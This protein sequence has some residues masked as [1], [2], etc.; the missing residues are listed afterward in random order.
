[1]PNL[2]F[3]V[4]AI[5]SGDDVSAGSSNSDDDVPNEHDR[6]F[7]QDS[8]PTQA[9]SSY[10]QTQVYRQSLLTQAPQVEGLMFATRPVRRGRFGNAAAR[11]RPEVLDSPSRYEE[12]PDQ[13]MLGSFV[14][15]DDEEIA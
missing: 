7:L 13:Y 2:L 4:E 14:V 11:P 6:S 3:D 10:E 12:M 1:M 5:H 15:D 8:P 9:A